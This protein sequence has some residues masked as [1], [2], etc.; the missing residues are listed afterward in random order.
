MSNAIQETYTVLF[1]FVRN[2]YY[3][4]NNK[5]VTYTI[6]GGKKHIYQKSNQKKKKSYKL[7]K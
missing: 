3:S 7:V 2:I 5:K 6:N 4:F 1:F